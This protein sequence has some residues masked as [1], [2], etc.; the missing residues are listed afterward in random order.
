MEKEVLR[1]G[2]EG[3]EEVGAVITMKVSSHII[4]GTEIRPYVKIAKLVPGTRKSTVWVMLLVPGKLYK[5]I[6]GLIISQH[7]LEV[8]STEPSSSEAPISGALSHTPP[9]S[10]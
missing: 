6:Y 10:L 4:I 3:E 5:D 9:I 2:L 7:G 1:V 8:M